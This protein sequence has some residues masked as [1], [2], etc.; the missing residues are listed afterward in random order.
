[1]E[2]SSTITFCR[3]A[4]KNM[5]LAEVALW[6]ALRGRR[7]AGLRFRR[8]HPIGPYIADFACIAARLVIEVDGAS[9]HTDA[10]RAHDMR[11]TQYLVDA[12]WHEIRVQNSSVLDDMP[13]VLEH[14]HRVIM[15]CLQ[16]R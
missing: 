12:G 16:Q 15:A 13:E 2:K 8:Q 10:A 6:R 14:I 7:M 3:N 11:R 9:H 4:R 1:M 5:P